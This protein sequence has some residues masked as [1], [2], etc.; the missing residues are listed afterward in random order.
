VTLHR[1]LRLVS[2]HLNNIIFSAVVFDVL[3]MMIC[4]LVKCRRD[5][6]GSAAVLECLLR[7]IMEGSPSMPSQLARCDL[8][9]EGWP[10]D[11]LVSSSSPSEKLMMFSSFWNHIYTISFIQEE[12]H[13]FVMTFVHMSFSGTLT[14]CASLLQACKN[15]NT[16]FRS[17][18]HFTS[19]LGRARPLTLLLKQR[20]FS[21]FMMSN[22]LC[23]VIGNGMWFIVVA[24]PPSGLQNHKLENHNILI[25]S[26]NPKCAISESYMMYVIVIVSSFLY[27]VSSINLSTSLFW[28]KCMKPYQ[29]K[30]ANWTIMRQSVSWECSPRVKSH[31]NDFID[32]V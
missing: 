11:R 8:R 5:I 15:R 20:T 29:L 17:L 16:R 32:K 4:G 31:K 12:C 14:C 25:L 23:W 9:H 26:S 6:T 21:T 2:I 28:D 19:S 30:W 3:V 22:Y 24:C 7:T 10:C 1:S 13:A 27:C 18:S